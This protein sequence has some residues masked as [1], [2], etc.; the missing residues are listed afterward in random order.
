MRNSPPNTAKLRC[1]ISSGVHTAPYP[2][3][4]MRSG[5]RP[6]R[7]SIP[8]GTG[9][10]GG[11]DEAPGEGEAGGGVD[12]GAGTIESDDPLISGGERYTHGYI[13]VLLLLDG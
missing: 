11:S 5:G 7:D 3:A 1:A 13:A 6:R 4:A 10:G 8:Y 9:Q 12:H 2:S